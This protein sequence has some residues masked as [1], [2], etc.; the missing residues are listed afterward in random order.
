MF[1]SVGSSD[2][3]AP[4]VAPRRYMRRYLLAMLAGGIMTALSMAA[5]AA[6]LYSRNA[7][8][9][10]QLSNSICIDEKLRM[11]RERPPQS[12]NL[13][14]IGSSV[15]WRHFNSPAAMATDASIRPYNAGLC[16]QSVAQTA[17]TAQWLLGRLPS[18]EHVMLLASPVDFQDCSAEASKLNYGDADGY[19]FGDKPAW[20][21]YLRYFDPVT[22][23]R[24][25]QGLAA[26]RSDPNHFE[27]LVIDRFGDGPMEPRQTRGLHYRE[28]KAF[29]R[30][31]LSSLSYL[32]QLTKE[33]D[34]AMDVVLT[35]VSPEWIRTY[36]PEGRV[37][38][39]LHDAVGKTAKKSGLRFV[40]MR[41]AF[42][43]QNFVDAIH[44]R[45]SVTAEFTRAIL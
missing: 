8:P 14:V 20:R 23:L 11:M 37:L 33:R 19:V 42:K 25:A 41:D 15:A 21:Y 2:I 29:D 24:N 1:I 32:A 3:I 43:D 26:R 12:P 17:E 7:L 30:K 45:Q 6:F 44:L 40:D 22:F 10:P 31:C 38:G 4:G 9:P 28:L 5:I 39:R 36:D 34:M 18:V 16:G 13:L 35:P 27:A